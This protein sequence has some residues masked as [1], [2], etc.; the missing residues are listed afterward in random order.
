[1]QFTWYFVET[2]FWLLLL[3]APIVL[4]LGLLVFS[5]GS[6]VNRI[7]GWKLGITAVFYYSF[8]TATTIGYGDYCPKRSFSR[9]LAIGIGFTGLIL[10][11]I[12]VAIGLHSVS[13]SL[14]HFQKDQSRSELRAFF[15]ERI[16]GGLESESKSQELK[17]GKGDTVN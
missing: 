7:E 4:F 16:Y 8:I 1:M 14:R 3:A 15:K 13:L 17:P 2:F 9:I 10:T 6:L 5:L 12:V 11:G